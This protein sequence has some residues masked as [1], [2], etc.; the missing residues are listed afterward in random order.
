[1]SSTNFSNLLVMPLF[2]FPSGRA[3]V[4]VV[5]GE[6]MLVGNHVLDTSVSICATGNWA[7]RADVST[8]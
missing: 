8:E 3:L 1:M 2:E 4:Y 5:N 6:D 7:R